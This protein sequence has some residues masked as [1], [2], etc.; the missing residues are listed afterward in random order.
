MPVTYL[1]Y[2]GCMHAE[3]VIGLISFTFNNDRLK[4]GCD[5]RYI[6]NGQIPSISVPIDRHIIPV[7][8]LSPAQ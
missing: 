6:I 3:S 4:R 5:L 7:L 1:I 8:I 2:V